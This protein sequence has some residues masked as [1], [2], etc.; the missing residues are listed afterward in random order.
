MYDNRIFELP[1]MRCVIVI[2]Y[3][4]IVFGGWHERCVTRRRLLRIEECWAPR[5]ATA[6]SEK[7]RPGV[8]SGESEDLAELQFLRRTAAPFGAGEF[9]RAVGGA[10][11]ERIK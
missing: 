3:M 7:H 1:V 10:D 5:V 9:E 8:L 2:H 11:H 6:M 4:T